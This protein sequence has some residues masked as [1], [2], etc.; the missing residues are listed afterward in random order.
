MPWYGWYSTK[1]ENMYGYVHYQ[2]KNINLLRKKIHKVNRLSLYYQ[3][4]SGSKF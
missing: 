1:E 3:N 4:I 2:N